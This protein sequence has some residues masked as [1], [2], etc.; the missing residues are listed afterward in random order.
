MPIVAAVSHTTAGRCHAKLGRPKEAAAA[1]E[2]AIDEARRCELPYLEMLAHSDYVVHVLDADG[3]RESQ[4]AAL[5]G[6][7][8]RMV[9]PAGA[10]AGFLGGGIDPGTA[11]AVFESLE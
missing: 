6:A 1:F 7:I 5:G 4:M 8:S 2:A 3:R 10:Y 11:V 9:L